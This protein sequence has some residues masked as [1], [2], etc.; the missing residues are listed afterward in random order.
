PKQNASI[1]VWKSPTPRPTP[2]GNCL[3]TGAENVISVDNS[4]GALDYIQGP[5]TINGSALDFFN[6]ADIGSS[7]NHTYTLA[8]VP[9]ISPTTTRLTRT[10]G[11]PIASITY[12][13]LNSLQMSGGLGTDTFNIESLANNYLSRIYG[14]PGQDIFNLSPTAQNMDAISG[15]LDLR[16]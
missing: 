7:D 15:I 14:S 10:G 6:V 8:A 3:N 4:A 16:A 5:L 2:D 1:E 11:I 9:S 12:T 13:G